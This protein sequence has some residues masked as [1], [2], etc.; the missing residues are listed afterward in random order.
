M[1]W[2]LGWQDEHAKPRLVANTTRACYWQTPA[3]Y[4]ATKPDETQ[5][6][7]TTGGYARLDSLMK[8][9]NETADTIRRTC[10]A[11]GSHMESEA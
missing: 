6:E 10:R 9:K 4:V 1:R 5:P 8:L 3:G 11:D 7:G 2:R